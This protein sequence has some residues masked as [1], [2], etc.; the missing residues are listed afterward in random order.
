MYVAYGK[1]S[2]KCLLN[3]GPLLRIVK[4]PVF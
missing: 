2:L 1:I 4:V 3:P